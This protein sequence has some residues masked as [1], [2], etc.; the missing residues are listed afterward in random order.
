MEERR[1]ILVAVDLMLVNVAVALAFAIWS[2]RGEISW[3]TLVT[4][5]FYWFVALSVLWLGAAFATGMYDLRLAAEFSATARALSRSLVLVV[6][7]YLV[8][9][10]SS[11]T[12]LPRGIVLY[13]GV[14]AAGLLAVWRAVYLRIAWRGA[15]RRNALIIGAGNA[16]QTIAR[17]MREHARPHYWIVGFLDDDPAKLGKP[18]SAQSDL[19]VLGASRDLTRLIAEHD[20]HEVV[21]A[22]TRDVSDETFRAL[23]DAQERAVEIVPMPVL[24]ERLTGRVPVDYIGDSWYVALP[25]GHAATRSIQPLVKRAFDLAAATLGSLLFGIALPFIA[26]A[27]GFDSPGPLF[28]MQER[29]GQGGRVF[30]VRKIRT[31]RVDAEQ[32]GAVWATKNDPRVT[33]VGKLLRKTHVDEFPQF[34][35]ILRGEMSAVG[36]RPERPEFV[37]QLEKKIPFYRLRHAV[38]PGMA[39]WALV[40]AGYVDSIEDAQT[41]VEY[42]LYYIKH[43]SLW[44]D[45]WILFRTVAQTITFGGR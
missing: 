42:D 26:L 19:R 45:L 16:G 27:V 3:V 1:T 12:E 15:F 41:R 30:R 6:V 2:V 39:G 4:T 9:F 10:F 11:P 21:L 20:A 29:V 13:H 44:F 40:N 18:V 22:I 43:Q 7:V 38:K 25:L 5:Q 28:Y 14:L 17:A 33:R 34:W 8:V 32:N 35:N 31:M 37:A 24:Y 23:L 36:P